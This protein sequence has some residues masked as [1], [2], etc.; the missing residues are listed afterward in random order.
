MYYNKFIL[1]YHIA[2]PTPPLNIICMICCTHKKNIDD[3]KNSL[4]YDRSF[5]S[6]ND[7]SIQTIG[8]SEYTNK[9]RPLL[10]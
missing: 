1:L 8:N 3:N 5:I 9:L 7:N 2:N 6:F 4:N 10:E